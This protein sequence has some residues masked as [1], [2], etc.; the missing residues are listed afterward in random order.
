VRRR[1]VEDPS[2][3]PGAV[4]DIM[5]FE[6]PVPAVN[7]HPQ[8]DIDLGDGLIVRK[9]ETLHC[10]VSAA[11]VDA[12]KFPDPLTVDIE[13]PRRQHIAFAS[14]IHRCLGSHL[15]RLELR[16]AVEEL[17]RRVPDFEID[18][19]DQA[20]YHNVVIRMATRLP[21]IFPARNGV[22]A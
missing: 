12:S 6:T 5:R 19:D 22:Q 13:R 8:E 10:V 17:L 14:G 9:G 15:S 2:L 21:V 3:I 16:V 18:P 7:R 4:E 20:E 11:N 1:L